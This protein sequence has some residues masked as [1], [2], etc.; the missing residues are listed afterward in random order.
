MGTAYYILAKTDFE[1][2]ECDKDQRK[3]R[4]RL[5]EGYISLQQA[6]VKLGLKAGKG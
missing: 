3:I 1:D 2:D 5:C 4:A 6:V